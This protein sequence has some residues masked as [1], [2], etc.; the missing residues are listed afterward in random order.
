MPAK[1]RST[2]GIAGSEGVLWTT[3]YDTLYAMVDRDDDLII[4]VR[5][6][7]ILFGR[8]DRLVVALLQVATLLALTYVGYLAGLGR[9]YVAGLVVAAG[10]ALHQQRLIR[11]RDPAQCFRAFL[12][13]NLFGFA[14]FGGILLD[15]L[16]ASG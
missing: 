9:W 1:F 13:N 3:A 16:W 10:T 8:A 14:V 5:S 6:S 12:N 2:L 4:G 7:A 15:Y 11:E